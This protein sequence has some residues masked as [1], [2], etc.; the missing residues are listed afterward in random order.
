MPARSL[1]TG[2]PGAT[3][4]LLA[5]AFISPA[6]IFLICLTFSPTA[7][8]S[9][10]ND[11]IATRFMKRVNQRTSHQV[12]TAFHPV[13]EKTRAATVEI[14]RDGKRRAMGVIVDADGW[15]ITKASL[16]NYH[17]ADA[18]LL[19]K[20][21]TGKTLEG[22][23]VAVDKK[24]DL[25]MVK[26]AGTNLPVATFADSRNPDVGSLL[27]TVGHSEDPL[28]IGVYSLSPREIKLKQAMLGVNLSQNPGPALVDAVVESSAAAKAGVTASDIIRKVNEEAIDTSNK[29]IETIR[30]YQPGDLL[31]LSVE[32]NDKTIDLE[33]TLG[34]WI[35][36]PQA[37]RHEFQNHLGGELSTRRSGFAA[38]FQHDSYIQ[39]ADCGSP[40]VNLE[41]KVVGLNIA[42]AG[43]VATFALPV[44]TLTETINRLKSEA[45]QLLQDSDQS[46]V[47]ST[48]GP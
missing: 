31:R 35:A 23:V 5:H 29:L 48:S 21:S 8:W 40:I 9:Q 7:A 45:T 6:L 37:A 43:R 18:P 42:R 47:V 26:V 27:A 36:G 24:A 41:G 39:P 12:L 3:R 44:S 11:G 1:T 38:V 16:V 13:V 10:V 2:R 34:E 15:V 4:S 20:L 14:E 30:Q 32:R 17:S 22:H 33:V 28:A 46:S 19:C 25:A